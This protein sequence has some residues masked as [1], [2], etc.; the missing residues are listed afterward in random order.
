MSKPVAAEASMSPEVRAAL[1][2]GSKPILRADGSV[3]LNG[4]VYTRVYP[5]LLRAAADS[6]RRW[7]QRLIQGA[8]K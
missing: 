5:E 6:R 3:E 1:R 4:K 2:G 8:A 7:W